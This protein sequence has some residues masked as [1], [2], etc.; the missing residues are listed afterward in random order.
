M[1]SQVIWPHATA[2]PVDIAPPDAIWSYIINVSQEV[3]QKRLDQ[4]L[5][6]CCGKTAIANDVVVFGR[7]KYEH[8]EHL[9]NLM[10]VARKT[11]AC[12]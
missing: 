11:W 6:L 2:S 1:K 9:Y 8:D 5:E 10:K 3:F 12:F 7:T 4:I